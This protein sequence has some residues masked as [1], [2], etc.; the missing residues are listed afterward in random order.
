MD[1]KNLTP[2]YTAAQLVRSTDLIRLAGTTEWQ[3]SYQE[4]AIISNALVSAAHDDAQL[5]R[6]MGRLAE[7]I[8]AAQY[9]AETGD[10]EQHDSAE[11]RLAA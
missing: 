7:K 10:T 6:A 4:L 11:Q 1:I 9:A 8:L 3:D 5:R 2:N